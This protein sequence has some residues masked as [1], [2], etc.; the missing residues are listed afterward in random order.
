MWNNAG[1]STSILITKCSPAN[2]MVHHMVAKIFVSTKLRDL[3]PKSSVTR[4]FWRMVATCIRYQPPTEHL[5]WDL[6]TFSLASVKTPC[7]GTGFVGLAYPFFPPNSLDDTPEFPQ[8][9]PICHGDYIS[10]IGGKDV[11]SLA[12]IT[13]L[14]PVNLLEKV[15]LSLKE[16]DTLSESTIRRLRRKEA[17]LR[18]AAAEGRTPVS[19]YRRRKRK[20]MVTK[21]STPQASYIPDFSWIG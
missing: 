17:E 8:I 15:L 21:T 5:L 16:G 13:P 3:G 11:I 20:R 10:A 18:A 19:E 9:L 12:V 4:T 14:P 2:G 7:V 1:L 6:T